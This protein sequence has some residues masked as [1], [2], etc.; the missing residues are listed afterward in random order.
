MA[1]DEVIRENKENVT[2]VW[3]TSSADN[4][5]R[6]KQITEDLRTL[7]DFTF[8]SNDSNKCI[9]LIKSV[10]KERIFLIMS[11]ADAYKLLPDISHLSQ[12]DS[13]YIYP[14]NRE[15]Y[16]RLFDDFY[17]IVNIFD[18]LDEVKISIKENIQHVNE[19]IQLF[20]FYDLYQQSIRDL[21]T[22]SADFLL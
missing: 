20:S 11:A 16:K 19:Q 3:L 10:D 9:D 2:L 5:E 6:N 1:E 4:A 17:K 14:G 8:I 22:Q 12:L 15:E 18:N 13:I 21:S 7:N